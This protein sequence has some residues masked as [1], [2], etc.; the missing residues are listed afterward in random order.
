MEL[1][2]LN[3]VK[4]GQCRKS[5]RQTITFKASSTFEGISDKVDEGP[6]WLSKANLILE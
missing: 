4:L 6:F 1:S 3:S 5:P 2:G